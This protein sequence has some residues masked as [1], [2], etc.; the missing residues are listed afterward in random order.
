[1]GAVG[2]WNEIGAAFEGAIARA[3]LPHANTSN[4]TRALIGLEQL[5][6]NE[7]KET[8]ENGDGSD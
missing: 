2:F 4:L 8:T 1:V 7:G 5:V 6:P 3:T